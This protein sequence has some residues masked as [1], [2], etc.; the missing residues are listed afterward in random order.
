MSSSQSTTTNNKAPQPRGLPGFLR[1]TFR[2]PYEQDVPDSP[3]PV[4]PND[5]YN[6]PQGRTTPDFPSDD[7]P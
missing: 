4:L 1:R 7:D 6:M 5:P 3:T 2:N